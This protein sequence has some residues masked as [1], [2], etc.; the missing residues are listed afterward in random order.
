MT[1]PVQPMSS[2]SLKL[3]K[4]DRSIECARRLGRLAQAEKRVTES[5]P[6]E[7]VL[8]KDDH[9][10]LEARRRVRESL[11]AEEIVRLVHQS[12]GRSLAHGL[13]SY[14]DLLCS[15]RHECCRRS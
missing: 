10:A 11:G 15:R 13:R 8:R 14:H 6:A 9:R 2:L 5:F 4:A 12:V 1:K 7:R 3:P